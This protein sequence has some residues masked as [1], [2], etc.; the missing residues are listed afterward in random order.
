MH[1]RPLTALAAAAAAA[2]LLAGC[3]TT[4]VDAQ[5][6]SVEL[7]PTYLRGSTVIVACESAELVLRRVCED[8]VAG[9]LRSR[10]IRVVVA[11]PGGGAVPPTGLPDQQYLPAAREQGAKA[12]M[13]VGVGLAAQSVSPPVSLSIGGFGFGRHSAGGVGVTAPIGGGQVSAGYAINARITDV[14]S[15]RLMWTARAAAPPS[16]DVNA[17]FAEL[18]GS[19]L[20]AARDAGLF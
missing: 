16:S 2:A 5:W 8:Q 18:T 15:G 19:V 17:Q 13:L 1:H 3:A 4:Q 10:G 6:R 12:V 7:P 11:A 14:A 20:D 9:D